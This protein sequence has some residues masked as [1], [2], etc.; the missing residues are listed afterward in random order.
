MASFIE[1]LR[2]DPQKRD[3]L[4]AAVFLLGIFTTLPIPSTGK[5]V[6]W[7]F[8]LTLLWASSGALAWSAYFKPAWT[9]ALWLAS[10]F[11]ASFLFWKFELLVPAT[12]LLLWAFWQGFRAKRV[13]TRL[14]LVALILIAG[15]ARA[16]EAPGA[17]MPTSNPPAPAP[18]NP[19]PVE[20]T[21][22]PPAAVEA[23]AGRPADLVITPD[24]DADKAKREQQKRDDENKLLAPPKD[25]KLNKVQK[26][27]TKSGHRR[28]S[29]QSRGA[30]KE[31][32]QSF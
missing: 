28:I 1:S 25:V 31:R 9:A 24:V 19:A 6:S 26:K 3:R 4:L 29:S 2:Q 8:A 7:L 13:D 21:P 12:L 16:Q 30:Q 10:F 5:S 32:T 14:G 15:F 17:P 18:A 11:I 20:V 23:P 22:A 27:K